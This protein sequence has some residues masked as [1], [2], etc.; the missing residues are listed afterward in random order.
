MKIIA[1][2]IKSKLLL[3]FGKVMTADCDIYRIESAVVQHFGIPDFRRQSQLSTTF[4]VSYENI[5]LKLLEESSL[6]SKKKKN[7]YKENILIFYQEK[8]D[9][10]AKGGYDIQRDYKRDKK[11]KGIRT[12]KDENRIKRK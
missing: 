1:I 10:M 8:R 11:K 6:F 3:L 4:L 2:D 5:S 9:K 12:V 7:L